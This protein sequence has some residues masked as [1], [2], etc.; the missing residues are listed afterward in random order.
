MSSSKD[1]AETTETGNSSRDLLNARLD[2]LVR[3]GALTVNQGHQVTL[4]KDGL[5]TVTDVDS[6]ANTKQESEQQRLENLIEFLE[7]PAAP[8]SDDWNCARENLRQ[9]RER[10][11]NSKGDVD[12]LAW[13]IVTDAHKFTMQRLRLLESTL[14]LLESKTL[15]PDR[16]RRINAVVEHFPEHA[17]DLIGITTPDELH[18]DVWDN[19]LAEIVLEK[20]ITVYRCI[21]EAWSALREDKRRGYLGSSTEPERF[22]RRF[23]ELDV[24]K[25]LKE[26]VY[27]DVFVILERKV[28]TARRLQQAST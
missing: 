4:D 3:S 7:S 11:V 8:Q 16:L 26:W 19:G 20:N 25:R 2:S 10:R 17:C 28:I 22:L 12:I 6:K 5:P 9:L 1:P 23:L 21:N 24:I 18:D 27:H 14:E 15:D 13:S